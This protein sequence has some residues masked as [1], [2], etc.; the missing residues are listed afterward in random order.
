MSLD[1]STESVSQH[2][3]NT[4]FSVVHSVL[5]PVMMSLPRSLSS[6]ATRIMGSSGGW[7]ARTA[8]SCALVSGALIN[9]G[10]RIVVECRGRVTQTSV[11]RST[12]RT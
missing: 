10:H 6:G 8:W 4:V 5:A 2:L 11:E 12:I 3:V 1:S 9:G 7:G